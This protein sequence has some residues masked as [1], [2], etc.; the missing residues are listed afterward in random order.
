MNAVIMTR[1]ND[2][3]LGGTREVEQWLNTRYTP[4]VKPT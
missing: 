2:L 4:N 1:H 3:D